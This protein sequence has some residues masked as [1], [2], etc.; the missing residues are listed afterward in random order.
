MSGGLTSQTP[1]WIRPAPWARLPLHFDPDLLRADLAKVAAEEWLP[2]YNRADY[3]G[4]WS[5]VALRSAGGSAAELFTN[6]ASTVFQATP[7]LERCPAFRT[8]I[9]AFQC[10]LRAVRLLR[11]RPGSRI[12]EHTDYGLNYESGDLRIHV[13]VETN[14]E[15]E[16]VVDG[17][18]LDL[19]PGEAWYIDFALPHRI[20]NRGATDRVHMVLD[21][22]VNDWAH[23][24]ISA[25]ERPAGIPASPAS[26]FEQ[27]RRLVFD[28]A[29]VRSPLLAANG[30]NE[31]LDLAVRLGREQ[32]F[33][34]TAADVRVALRNG[35]RS[36]VEREVHW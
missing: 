33:T 34:F 30:E 13:P 17:R 2:H 14:P 23:G 5:G 12:L 8:V 25:A 20:H 27:F 18:R 7:V 22:L 6:P 3:D 26:D 21:G 9:A 11:L 1:G 32:G 16:F 29:A 36:W 35:H 28:D 19:A 10:P 15:T 4:D 24:M 31:L